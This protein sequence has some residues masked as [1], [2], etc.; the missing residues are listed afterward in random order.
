LKQDVYSQPG[1]PDPVL[2]EE[3]VMG[4]VRRCVPGARRMTGVD[5][6]GGEARTYAADEDVILKVQRPHRLRWRTALEKEVFFLRQIEKVNLPV[7]RVL[8]YG[9]DG[10]IEYTCMTRIPGIPVCR[11]GL[12][13]ER[14]RAMLVELGKVLRAIHSLDPKPFIESGL[15]PMDEDADLA[16]RLRRRAVSGVRA[17]KEETLP[18]IE[19]ALSKLPPVVQFAAVHSNPGATHTFVDE[20]D[21]RFTGLIDFGDAYIGH[22]VLDLLRWN[23]EERKPLL[24]GYTAENPLD[25]AFQAVLQVVDRL[26]E[27]IED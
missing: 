7:P 11:A 3:T 19:A 10:G 13:P 4:I 24:E 22:P 18:V 9:R 12:S 26:D 27:I 17:Q 6:S 14:R 20:T 15:F 2:T 1:A 23:A 5:E 16:E 25:G 21:G 8:G